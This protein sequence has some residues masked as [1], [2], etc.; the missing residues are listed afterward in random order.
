MNDDNNNNK[1]NNL[2]KFHIKSRNQGYSAI[3]SN[4]STCFLYPFELFKIRMQS[5]LNYF[6]I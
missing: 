6:N 4:L 1:I 5:N 2:S 3:I